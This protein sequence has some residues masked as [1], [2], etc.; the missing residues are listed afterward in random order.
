MLMVFVGRLLFDL[1]QPSSSNLGYTMTSPK[2]SRR[3]YQLKQQGAAV[4]TPS[5]P[6]AVASSTPAIQEGDSCDELEGGDTSPPPES[7]QVKVRLRY[8]HRTPSPEHI[9]AVQE[10]TDTIV[11]S[12][13]FFLF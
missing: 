10:D 13:P 3:D 5:R 1:L 11:V 6:A 8:T 4:A 9:R 12:H 7:H 2:L